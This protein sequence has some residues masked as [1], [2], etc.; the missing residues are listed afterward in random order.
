MRISSQ[1][2]SSAVP[3]PA[4]DYL[5]IGH[6]SED[7]TP[8][9]AA[10]GGT[11]SYS[12]LTAHALGHS[13]GIVTSA[14]ESADLAPLQDLALRVKSSP[15]STSFENIYTSEGRQQLLHSQAVELTVADVPED[16]WDTELVHVAP[17]I[18]ELAE[19][20]ATPF[21]ASFVGSTPQGLMRE[22]DVEG[23]VHLSSWEYAADL[24]RASDAV[25]LGIEDLDM[26]EEAASAVAEL[27]PITV[28]TYGAQGIRIGSVDE[29]AKA[30]RKALKNE[31][32]TVID[33]PIA[34]EENVFPMV[35][36]GKG[37]KDTVEG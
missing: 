7:R 3:L 32:T 17:L 36:P 5:L 23:R 22:S 19:D 6:L 24:I 2:D 18:G 4:V 34:P 29:F 11:V 15:Q 21:Q 14:A 25:V 28:I 16:W 9:G 13:V 8:D 26:N 31:V 30:V 10:L 12:G 37:L 20:I 35:P 33:V 1:S 27:C